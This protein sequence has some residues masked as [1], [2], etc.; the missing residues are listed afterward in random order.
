MSAAQS[1]MLDEDGEIVPLAELCNGKP[2]FRKMNPMS[3]EIVI[4]S[5]LIGKH[6]PNIVEIYHVCDDYI[7]MELL[8]INHVTPKDEWIAQM[9]VAKEFLQHAL[10]V[11][12]IDWKNDNTGIRPET[13]E[14]VLFDFNASGI[15]TPRNAESS[16]T[17]WLRSPEFEGFKFKQALRQ[18]DNRFDSPYLLDDICFENAL[19]LFGVY[20]DP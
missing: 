9:C 20:H 18:S 15:A 7:D 2:F 19:D 4:A 16:T 5:M 11:V 8:D 3:N 10:G 6:H 14:L 13:G 1:F 17:E 12:Y